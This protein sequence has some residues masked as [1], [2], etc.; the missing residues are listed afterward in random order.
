MK[1]CRERHRVQCQWVEFGSLAIHSKTQETVFRT[2]KRILCFIRLCM[3]SCPVV[4]TLN[5]SACSSS[6]NYDFGVRRYAI[7]VATPQHA[8]SR[9]QHDARSTTLCD[10]MSQEE[11]F[12]GAPNLGC[13]S[14]PK[15]GGFQ[16]RVLSLHLLHR[17]ELSASTQQCLR[18]S[19]LFAC[20]LL[21]G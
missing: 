1:V 13:K 11:E 2:R 19:V 8:R 18:Q 17:I 16:R 15:P 21:D 10:D 14:P 5:C 12:L 9:P 4:T 3:Q 20:A 6:A 7:F